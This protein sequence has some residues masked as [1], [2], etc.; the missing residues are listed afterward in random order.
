MSKMST[1]FENLEFYIPD[2]VNKKI[3]D[4]GSGKGTFLVDSVSHGAEVFGVELN[5][6]YIRIS[7][8]LARSK[9]VEINIQQ[10]V[11]EHIPF[12]NNSFDF[13]NMSEV[14]EHVNEPKIVLCEVSRVLKFR[15][16]VYISVPSRFS[17]FDAHFQLAFVNWLPRSWSDAYINFFGY[18]KDYT[19]EAGY[20]R[21]SE[22]HYYTFNKFVRLATDTGLKIKD[23]RLLKIK[24]KFKN[25]ILIFFISSIYIFIRPWY[26]RAFHFMLYKI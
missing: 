3:L 21:L 9:G 14:I 1:H 16:E 2:L 6:E 13:V 12:P 25:N 7:R 24:K 22:M 20:Q 15:G 5:E 11:A 4:L 18:H 8:E 26:F 17:W 23:M 10:G 19:G